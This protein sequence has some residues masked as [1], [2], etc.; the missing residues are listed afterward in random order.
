LSADEGNRA[1]VPD[2]VVVIST[3]LYQPREVNVGELLVRPLSPTHVFLITIGNGA[4]SARYM[5]TVQ[6]AATTTHLA[7]IDFNALGD[8]ELPLCESVNTFLGKLI[9]QNSCA[10]S[11]ENGG[12]FLLL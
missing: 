7:A 4:P 10:I 1:I 11:V 8:L 5:H 9:S 12:V 2:V 6:F 3:S